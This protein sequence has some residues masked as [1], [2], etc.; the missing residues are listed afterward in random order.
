MTLVLEDK[1]KNIA[2]LDT[3]V[4]RLE[5]VVQVGGMGFGSPKSAKSRPQSANAT[6]NRPQSASERFASQMGGGLDIVEDEDEDGLNMIEVD[7]AD[8]VQDVK[9]SHTGTSP[10]KKRRP[11]TAGA[12]RVGKNEMS[13]DQA[14]KER[15]A[16]AQEESA[17]VSVLR[18]K[19]RAKDTEVSKLSSQVRAL[20]HSE[21][22]LKNEIRK[23]AGY[24]KGVDRSADEWKNKA[25]DVRERYEAELARMR[26][27][28]QRSASAVD[29]RFS[30]I[31]ANADPDA[32][33]YQR[34]TSG[35]PGEDAGL[36]AIDDA[37]EAN[38]E[39]LKPKQRM[40]SI[41]QARPQSA[42]SKQQT[43][44]PSTAGPSR[45]SGNLK[46]MLGGSASD[47]KNATISTAAPSMGLT[48]K[49][50][51]DITSSFTG[52]RLQPGTKS[53]SQTHSVGSLLSS[54]QRPKSASSY[55]PEVPF[56]FLRAGDP[57]PY[58]HVRRKLGEFDATVSTQGARLP[59]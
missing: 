50:G 16:K 12:E 8:G 24:R 35:F 59:V 26:T 18:D 9:Q 38:M 40:P 41:T 29:N 43:R 48:I 51:T 47:E 52:A 37:I 11:Q 44:R 1:N 22:V 34:F 17:L 5:A 25:N 28:V 2:K 14:R 33:D 49:K 19:I 10:E 58:A 21:V 30:Y 56:Y 7:P 13:K 20:L 6:G 23:E 4:K 39:A 53:M 27:Q 31:T 32:D 15:A 42:S 46:E 36:R 3:K 57:P 45:P 55:R 54:K